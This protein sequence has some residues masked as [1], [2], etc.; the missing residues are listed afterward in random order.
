M[1]LLALPAF[2]SPETASPKTEAASPIFGIGKPK[3]KKNKIQRQ[4]TVGKTNH[5]ARRNQRKNG[6][7]M[8]PVVKWKE[9]NRG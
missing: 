5:R 1:L 8:L 9:V 6:I 4:N 2:S 3:Y 7:G